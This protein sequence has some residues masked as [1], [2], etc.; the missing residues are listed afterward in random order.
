MDY[1]LSLKQSA[2]QPMYRIGKIT[3][4]YLII[5]IFAFAYLTREEA[6]YRLYKLDRSSKNLVI[7]LYNKF[8]SL[9]PHKLQKLHLDF[10]KLD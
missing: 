3:N 7:K 1:S 8:P 5:D 10:V 4:K 6:I 9:I 2:G